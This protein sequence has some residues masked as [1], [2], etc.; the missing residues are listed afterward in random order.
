[1]DFLGE[2][3]GL[4][5]ILRLIFSFLVASFADQRIIA[6]LT[7]RL[8]HISARSK[9]ITDK[10]PHAEFTN[11]LRTRPSGDVEIAV[12]FFLDLETF[13]YKLTC[14]HSKSHRAYDEALSLG[15]QNLFNELDVIRYI[16]RSRMHGI[17]LNFLLTS[18]L[19]TISGRL[20]FSKPL[21]PASIVAQDPTDLNEIPDPWLYI[22]DIKFADRLKFAFYKRYLTHKN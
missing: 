7:N 3:G 15:K 22:E 4:V 10:M 21:N 12:P 19:R 13:L 20:A 2:V 14:K 17:G 8:Y 11:K 18:S 5:D 16:K 1:L 9:E 6:I